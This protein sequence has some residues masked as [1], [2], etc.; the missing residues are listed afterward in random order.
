MRF[1]DI[2]LAL[3]IIIIFILVFCVGFFVSSYKKIKN[4]WPEYA[5]TPMVMPFASQFGHDTG[6]NFTKCIGNMQSGMMDVFTTPMHYV[7][8]T[9]MTSIEN[10]TKNVS[11][12]RNL[13]NFMRGGL[14]S[15]TGSIFGI[16]QNVLIQFQKMIMSIRDLMSKLLGVIGTLFYMVTGSMLLGASIINGPI[17]TILDIVSFGAACFHPNTSI[18]LKGG[19][20][21]AIKD[22]H[23]GD[24]LANGSKVIGTLQLHGTEAN[25]YYKIYS[26][27]STTLYLCYR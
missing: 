6:E 22:I 20:Y 8:G 26:K 10:L 13:Q 4:N 19:K 2:F 1:K 27:E 9:L 17:L 3:I 21:C 15:F 11:D 24:V 25:T 23:L 18:Q 14:G 5:C 12:L 16:I 7:T